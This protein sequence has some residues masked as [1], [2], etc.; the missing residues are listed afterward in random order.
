MEV[1][2]GSGGTGLHRMTDPHARAV[3]RTTLGALLLAG[4]GTGAPL[5]ASGPGPAFAVLQALQ[6]TAP[7]FRHS[8][9]EAL[10]CRACHEMDRTH[11]ARLVQDIQ[12]CRS[13]HHTERAG[14]EC[15]GCHRE[16]ELQA[17]TYPV[18]R[19]F[20]LSVLDA[21]A[22]REIGFR[23]GPHEEVE[24]ARCHEDGPSL[25]APELDCQSCHEDHHEPGTAAA[26]FDCHLRPDEEAHDLS[27]HVTCSS[28]GCH[29][30]VPVQ[31]SPR[32]RNGC[33]WC[34]EDMSDH[35]TGRSCVTC[36][37]MPPAHPG[38]PGGGSS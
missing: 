31:A 26:C 34:H 33:L 5:G 19:T 4:L 8:Q 21:P 25:A 18:S 28:S 29:Q 30:E 14:M 7:T 11:G 32:T 20:S 27:V 38:S 10:E 12:D 9:H 6:D 17:E 37:V 13:C 16:A 22:R 1:H 3:M 15:V 24:C 2:P 36:H 23:H 35:K